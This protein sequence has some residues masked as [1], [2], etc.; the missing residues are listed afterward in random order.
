[1]LIHF[2]TVGSSTFEVVSRTDLNTLVIRLV[3]GAGGLADNGEAYTINETIQAY[4]TSDN[5]FDL[6]LDTE[7]TGT[8]TSNTF[9]QSTLF[10][11]VVNVRQGKIILPFTQNAAVTGSGGAVTVV[12]Q[13]DTI[14]T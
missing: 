8:T 13:P 3:Y 10:D 12:R 7:A 11:T 2:A 9:V 14:A 5:I 4:D 6:I 1:M